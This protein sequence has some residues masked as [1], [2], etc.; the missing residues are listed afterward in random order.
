VCRQLRLLCEFDRE[1]VVAQLL[2]DVCEDV[3]VRALPVALD[4]DDRRRNLVV[5]GAVDALAEVRHRERL[6][7]VAEDDAVA[8]SEVAKVSDRV[9]CNQ[10]RF[11]L[12]LCR[13][14]C[15]R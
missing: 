1:A 15:C 2:D 7:A 10:Y 12:G 6:R 8:A 4:T 14:T 9:R 13:W 3:R 5:A 11:A